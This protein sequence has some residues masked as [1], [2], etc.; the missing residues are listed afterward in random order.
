MNHKHPTCFWLPDGMIW[1]EKWTPKLYNEE[2]VVEYMNKPY[3][4]IKNTTEPDT[5]PDVTD[6]WKPLHPA[7]YIHEEWESK[8]YPAGSIVTYKGNSF[9][10]FH[11]ATTELPTNISYWTQCKYKYQSSW[12]SRSYHPGDNV[13]FKEQCYQCI[14]TSTIEKPNN[15]AHWKIVETP[16]KWVRDWYPNIY[17]IYDIVKYND[18]MYVC[19]NSA[20]TQSPL[21]KNHWQMLPE[22]THWKGKWKYSSFPK[23]TIVRNGDNL[24]V[25]RQEATSQP[26]ADQDT[27]FPLE[28]F[29]WCSVWFNQAYVAG[30]FV[31]Y[32]QR[33]YVCI[34]DSSN[35]EHPTDEDF[36]MLFYQGGV[37]FPPWFPKPRGIEIYLPFDQELCYNGSSGGY[38]WDISPPMLLGSEM[39]AFDKMT[40]SAKEIFVDVPEIRQ[41]Y[42]LTQWHIGVYKPDDG[43][44]ETFYGAVVDGYYEPPASNLDAEKSPATDLVA[45]VN[46]ITGESGYRFYIQWRAGDLPFIAQPDHM[47]WL[48]IMNREPSEKITEFFRQ[49]SHHIQISNRIRMD[50]VAF[51]DEM[52]DVISQDG[53]VEFEKRRAEKAE[54]KGEEFVPGSYIP[55]VDER[56]DEWVQKKHQMKMLHLQLGSALYEKADLYSK[57]WVDQYVKK[58]KTN[59]REISSMVTTGV[60]NHI[61]L[62]KWFNLTASQ[63]KKIYPNITWSVQGEH[64]RM[65]DIEKKRQELDEMWEE[66]EAGPDG[67]KTQYLSHLDYKINSILVLFPPKKKPRTNRRK[68]KK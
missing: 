42:M 49:S 52:R 5:L 33:A 41:I 37:Q 23:N 67:G 65:S 17:S 55:Y 14:K 58:L 3:V 26:L 62:D 8:S 47:D 11:D 38:F 15:Y 68:N 51:E 35:R 32:D 13:K 22:K 48:V 60:Q 45:M 6:Y 9:L 28:K 1:Q 34:K 40:Q 43:P 29:N 12:C 66:F 50:K 61:G 63:C 44:E 18:Q 57:Q 21:T 46:P 56:M 19:T 64:H 36:W 30:D 10:C 24:Y 4:C 20:T 31:I 59:T 53:Y 25:A 16:K 7:D 39:I 54:L 2:D 27:W